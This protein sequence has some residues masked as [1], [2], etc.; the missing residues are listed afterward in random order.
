MVCWFRI[1]YYPP[2]PFSFKNTN[3]AGSAFT[4]ETNLLT[5]NLFKFFKK[6]MCVQSNIVVQVV[7]LRA[8]SIGVPLEKAPY[9]DLSI[10][11]QVV[12]VCISDGQMEEADGA[13]LLATY[14]QKL[15]MMLAPGQKAAQDLATILMFA[16][17]LLL[18]AVF[19]S[20][21]VTVELLL[22]A[23]YQQDRDELMMWYN[24]MEG[25]KHK[26]AVSFC[27]DAVLD[28]G[29]LS[30]G[31]ELDAWYADRDE[32]TASETSATSVTTWL[33]LSHGRYE[34]VVRHI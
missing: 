10:P 5:G 26:L 2:V 17:F 21:G 34:R 11:A 29:S 20:V 28:A 14:A 31:D 25:D 1:F 30:D 12:E 7:D 13:E 4:S 18:H 27:C 33:Y 16:T 22:C 15:A 6:R 9:S 23:C 24:K 19:F 8:Q 3:L 32:T